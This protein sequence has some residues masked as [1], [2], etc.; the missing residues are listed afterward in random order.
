[1]AER[2]CPSPPSHSPR[3]ERI[4]N[5]PHRNRRGVGNQI[6]TRFHQVSQVF[7]YIVSSRKTVEDLSVGTVRNQ[8][9]HT[10]SSSRIPCHPADRH[11]SI[12]AVLYDSICLHQWGPTALFDLLWRP[13]IS[14]VHIPQLLLGTPSWLQLHLPTLGHALNCCSEIHPTTFLIFDSDCI[15]TSHTR[16]TI[17]FRFHL[18][19]TFLLSCTTMLSAG[20]ARTLP[21][22]VGQGSRIFCIGNRLP[23]QHQGQLSLRKDTLNSKCMSMLTRSSGSLQLHAR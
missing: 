14:L 11:R 1:M 18:F 2:G 21:S 19:I 7:E 8:S 15:K 22:R 16:L 13:V 10:S 20:A 23:I 9:I 5:P 4:N 6:V 12:T 3:P 17:I